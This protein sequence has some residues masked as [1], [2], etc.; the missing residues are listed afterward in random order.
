MPTKQDSFWIGGCNNILWG[1]NVIDMFSLFSFCSAWSVVYDAVRLLTNTSKLFSS[2]H[3]S[4]G[5]NYDLHL[6]CELAEDKSCRVAVPKTAIDAGLRRLSVWVTGVSIFNDMV[7]NL[8]YGRIEKVKKEVWNVDYEKINMDWHRSVTFI[9]KRN[10]YAIWN[11]HTAVRGQG[12]NCS[13]AWSST[14]GMKRNVNSQHT[15]NQRAVLCVKR[16]MLKGKCINSM[17]APNSGA[18]RYAS[19]ADWRIT[20]TRLPGSCECISSQ[21]L[22]WLITPWFSQSKRPQKKNRERDD[23]RY[24]IALTPVES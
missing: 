7:C 16:L 15:A 19:A 11:R 8:L 13:C 6:F 22:L 24:W 4:W 9:T 5:K 21:S 14:C 1:P 3:G 20:T 17:E 23:L 2:Y 10:S 18:A 12:T